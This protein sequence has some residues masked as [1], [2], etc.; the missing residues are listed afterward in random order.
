LI[1]TFALKTADMSSNIG[2][3]LTALINVELAGLSLPFPAPEPAAVLA[4]T[5]APASLIDHTLLAPG[6][7]PADII[8]VTEEAIML[9]CATVCV[10]SSYIPLVRDTLAGAVT[11]V[12]IAVVG[13]PLGAAATAAKVFEAKWAIENGAKEI[14]MV[15]HGMLPGSVWF[16]IYILTAKQWVVSRQGTISMFLKT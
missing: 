4:L 11:P 13:F 16:V 6:A 15:H 5:S 3:E 2:A 7:Q 1:K 12:P 10:N 8:R 9:R 14:D